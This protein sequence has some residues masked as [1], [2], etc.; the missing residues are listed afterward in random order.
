MCSRL[1]S[2]TFR[3]LISETLNPTFPPPP[4][5]SLHSPHHQHHP[6]H[7]LVVDFDVGHILFFAALFLPYTD[8][9]TPFGSIHSFGCSCSLFPPTLFSTSTTLKAATPFHYPAQST[10]SG[11]AASYL[12]SPRKL[13]RPSA[14]NRSIAFLQIQRRPYATFD[15][16]RFLLLLDHFC[17]LLQSHVPKNFSIWEEGL[18]WD[19]YQSL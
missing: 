17:P 8:T 2:G 18:G 15:A 7:L 14:A 19:L 9:A 11:P 1:L 16:K 5:I 10:C 3:G 12:A 6:L 13:W 4:T